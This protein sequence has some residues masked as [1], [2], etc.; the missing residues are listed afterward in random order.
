MR[1]VKK[2]IFWQNLFVFVEFPAIVEKLAKVFKG[3]ILTSDDLLKSKVLSED[4]Q[5]DKFSDLEQARWLNYFLDLFVNCSDYHLKLKVL[6]L[7]FSFN[8]I[9]DNMNALS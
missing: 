4:F 6:K 1:V 8:F 5:A 9:Q 2:R 7:S 3:L